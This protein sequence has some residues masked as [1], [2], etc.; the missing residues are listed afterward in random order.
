MRKAVV[1]ILMAAFALSFVFLTGMSESSRVW[2]QDDAPQLIKL[3]PKVITTGTQTF[4]LRIDG[5]RINSAANILFDG[6]PLA[7]PRVTPK[8]KQILAEVDAS[9]VA[10]PG[11]HTI[12]IM[13]P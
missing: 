5:K 2:S 7:S 3:R 11:D 4:T 8:G 1:F 6:V 10:S 9:L 13:N 12:Q